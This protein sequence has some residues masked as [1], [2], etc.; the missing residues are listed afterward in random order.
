[1]VSGGPNYIKLEGANRCKACIRRKNIYIFYRQYRFLYRYRYLYIFRQYRLYDCLVWLPLWA[2]E[3]YPVICEAREHS[4]NKYQN[5][6]RPDSTRCQKRVRHTSS[7]N[8]FPS[9]TAQKTRI[10]ASHSQKYSLST[11]YS[12]VCGRNGKLEWQPEI[13]PSHLKVAASQRNKKH[14]SGLPREQSQVFS[15]CV[16]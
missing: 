10:T 12:P 15:A 16:C 2:I 11:L 4:D 3:F 14:I 1:M 8:L 13:Q 5:I 6:P 7:I 9:N